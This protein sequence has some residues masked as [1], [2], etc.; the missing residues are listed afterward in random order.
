MNYERL[1]PL[2]G[3]YVASHYGA[4]RMKLGS[5]ELV[6]IRCNLNFM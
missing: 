6:A 2:D 4:A 1:D 5:Q 3:G